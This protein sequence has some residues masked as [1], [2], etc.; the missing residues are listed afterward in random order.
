LPI[1]AAEP[2][3]GW[4]VPILISVSVTPRIA[5]HFSDTVR[6]VVTVVSVVVNFGPV[7]TFVTVVTLPPG[8]VLVDV[9]DFVEADATVPFVFSTFVVTTLSVCF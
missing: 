1:E 8:I 4:L 9:D 5:G 6:S 3:S 7:V 2:L